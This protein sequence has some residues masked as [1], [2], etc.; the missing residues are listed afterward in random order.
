MIEVGDT[1]RVLA[2]YSQF[3]GQE[4]KVL[5]YEE[6]SF[7]RRKISNWYLLDTVHPKYKWSQPSW[8]EIH[9]IKKVEVAS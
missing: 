9:E 7:R 5:R 1:V 6:D 3:E 8:F 2:K 4:V